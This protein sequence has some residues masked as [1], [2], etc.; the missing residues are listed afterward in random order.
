MLFAGRLVRQVAAA[1]APYRH[2]GG[3]VVVSARR[4]V[5]LFTVLSR[6]ELSRTAA[7]GF[8]LCGA[9][10][11]GV[12]LVSTGGRRLPAV[13]SATAAAVVA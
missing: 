2:T 1:T 10:A 3:G 4:R 6:L 11:T 9:T 13:E 5:S 7:R 12:R 8:G